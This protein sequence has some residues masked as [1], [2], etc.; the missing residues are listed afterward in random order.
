MSHIE[1]IRAFNRDYTSRLGLLESSYL[2]SGL[3][4]TQVRVLQ[5][6][7]F[8][9]EGGALAREIAQQIGADEGYMSRIISGFLRKGW[10]RREADP[11]DARRKRL[12]LTEAGQAA[13]SP[14]DTASRT[15]LNTMLAPLPQ[16]GRNELCR[17]LC[18]VQSLLGDAPSSGVT[19]RD[20]ESGDL[21]WVIEAHG[22]LYARDE[23]Y[24]LDF[25]A[26]VAQ[27]VAEF[28]LKPHAD[29]RAFIAIDSQG[30]RLGSTF[31]VH[32]APG[33]ARLRLVLLEP[34]ARGLG[35]GRQ[36]LEAAMDHARARGCQ[37]MVL[38]THESHRA[39][40][41]LYE[42]A[43]FVLTASTPGQDFGVDVVDQTWEI[44]L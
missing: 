20:L 15:L 25:E 35:L 30:H 9:G 24:N 6:I 44:A 27:I 14:I 32:E 39:A 17:A 43:G 21:G 41:A 40:C 5:E 12:W 33:V 7:S 28:V 4:L 26:L 2:G 34:E 13:F 11:T 38:W 19:L 22:R 16:D 37:K 3:T 1:T 18:R 42:K 10:L 29:N 36:L 8:A 23:G 31:V